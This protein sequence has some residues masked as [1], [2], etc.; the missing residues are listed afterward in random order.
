MR[1]ITKLLLTLSA[2]FLLL[3]F[4][5]TAASAAPA[6]EKY[7]TFKQPSGETFTAAPKGDEVFNYTATE[8]GDV[9]TQGTDGYWY[10]AVPDDAAGLMAGNCKYI[11]DTKPDNAL[12]DEDIPEI[13][14][15][16]LNGQQDSSPA[17]S[18]A[19]PDMS[20]SIPAASGAQKTLV[21]LVSFSNIQIQY[22]ESEWSNALFGTSG[23]TVRTYYQEVSGNKLD[24]VP[25]SESYGTSGDGVVSVILPYSHPN[26]DNNTDSRNLQLAKDAL[27][28]ANGYVNYADFDSNHDGYISTSELHIVTVAAGYERSFGAATPSVWAHHAS[29]YGAVPPPVLDGVR[30]CNST[31]HGAYVQIGEIHADHMATIGAVCHELGHD[32]G[33]PDLYDTDK[34][35]GE[36]YGVGYY[37][38]MGSGSWGYDYYMYGD[39]PGA[40]P[41]HLDAWSKIQLGFVTPTVAANPGSYAVRSM[42]GGYNVI[43]I[44]TAVPAEY[45]LIEYRVINGFDQGLS[46][47]NGYDGIAI[48]HIDEAVIEANYAGN[49]VNGDETH[50]GVDLEEANYLS[51]GGSQL[52]D[53]NLKGMAYDNL[54]WT[55]QLFGP[56]TAPDS[57]LY[58]GTATGIRIVTVP[59]GLSSMSMIN[60]GPIT[61]ISAITGMPEVGNLLTAGEVSLT[62]AT[63]T[64]QWQSADTLTGSFSNIPGA[65]GYQYAPTDAELGKYIRVN[66]TAEGLYIGMVTSAAVGPVLCRVTGIGI[67]A[68]TPQVGSTLEAGGVVPSGAAIAYQW[69]RQDSAGETAYSITDANE[70]TYT[71]TGADAGKYIKVEVT[72]TGAY[73][74]SAFS[75]IFGPVTSPANALSGIELISGTLMVGSELTAGAVTP[76]GA[77]FTYQWLRANTR[78]GTYSNIEGATG[79]TYVLADIDFGKYIRV[80][81][82]GTGAYS[83]TARSYSVGRIASATG[84]LS[85]NGTGLTYNSVSGTAGVTVEASNN[86]GSD[87]TVDFLFAAYS[88]T[89]KLLNAQVIGGVP[90]AAHSGYSNT[91]ILSCGPLLATVTVKIFAIDRDSGLTPIA[92]F[93]SGSS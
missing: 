83:G 93:W 8:S 12:T 69:Y 32:L 28:A 84:A 9:V 10:Y 54:F 48:W 42:V 21:L 58:S 52:D 81:A 65:T 38:L 79:G 23:K 2:T 25:A 80:I 78:S 62:E 1:C 85:I 34:S 77:T 20:V 68:G 51:Y 39:N 18:A 73:Y 31:Y 90:V 56:D 24:I 17:M 16:Q 27:T 45:F 59:Q 74:G 76:E 49:T 89:G 15:K 22:T 47:Y 13:R 30:L 57:N 63:V 11:I 3:L 55:Y 64:Y 5:T 71:L 4:I 36:S 37:S 43:K 92:A 88:S 91:V 72:G 46:C 75:T 19:N 29:L 50:K 40:T 61:S 87:R 6:F 53:K 26:T 7:Q 35:N 44:N 14:E 60:V 82:T 70:S 86:T 66:A 41:T 33:L 67:V